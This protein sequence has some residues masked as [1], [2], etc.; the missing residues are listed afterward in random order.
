MPKNTSAGL[1]IAGFSM[2]FGFAMIWHIYWLIAVGIIGMF[3]CVI[4]RSFDYNIDYY[5][6]VAEVEK[7]EAAT[8]R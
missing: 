7:I 4:A 5:V 3:A 6:T 2:V 1:L 8:T